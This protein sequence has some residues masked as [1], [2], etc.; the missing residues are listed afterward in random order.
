MIDSR[1]DETSIRVRYAETDTMGVAHH[2]NYII[3]FEAGRSSFMRNAGLSYAEVEKTGNYFR[4]AE[5]GARYLA[6]AFYDELI[7][8]RTW[9]SEL[10]SRGVTFS[11]SVVRPASA[12]DSG[13]EQTLTTGFTRLICTDAQGHVRRIPDSLRAALQPPAASPITS[14]F[15]DPSQ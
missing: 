6:P 4:I 8:V 9:V 5:I 3:W 1:I 11:Y 2:S 13:A 10:H 12:S 15:L 14:R 7:T